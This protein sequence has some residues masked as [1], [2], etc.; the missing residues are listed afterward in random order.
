MNDLI[1]RIDAYL[2]HKNEHWTFKTH[3][4]LLEDCKAALEAKGEPVAYITQAALDAL[5]RGASSSV[6]V[7]RKPDERLNGDVALYTKENE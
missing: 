7:W 5:K 1:K 3:I 6:R 2:R 4:M